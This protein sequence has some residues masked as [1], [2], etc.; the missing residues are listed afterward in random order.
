MSPANRRLEATVTGRVQGVG[1]RMFVLDRASALGLVGWVANEA[2]GRVR[3]VAEGSEERLLQLLGS[4]RDGPSGARVDGLSEGWAEAT[5]EFD[6]FRVRG[7]WTSG[8]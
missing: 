4:L 3:V 5:G 8:D 1:F 2:G 6:G 7:G